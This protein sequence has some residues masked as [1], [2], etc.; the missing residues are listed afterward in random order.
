MVIESICRGVNHVY[1][2]ESYHFVEHIVMLM[3]SRYPMIA[4]R[5]CWWRKSQCWWQESKTTYY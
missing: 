5:C 4:I 3:G 1:T 2:K